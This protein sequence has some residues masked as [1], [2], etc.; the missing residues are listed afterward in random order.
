M[1]FKYPSSF[2][3]VLVQ[4]IL[5]FSL[6]AAG[7]VYPTGPLSFFLITIGLVVALWAV[8]TLFTSTRFNSTPEVAPGGRLV[9]AGPYKYLRHPLYSATLIFGLGLFFND[10]SFLRFVLLSLLLLLLLYKIKLEE[11]YLSQ[12]FSGYKDYVKTT[13]RLFPFVY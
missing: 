10:L 1:Y 12:L 2:I 7:P 4:L 8:W 5:I 9:T 3:L 11:Y 6:L 13:S